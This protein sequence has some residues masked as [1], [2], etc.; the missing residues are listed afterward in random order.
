MAN[1]EAGRRKVVCPSTRGG[2][3]CLHEAFNY[4]FDVILD[5]E[6]KIKREKFLALQADK[7]HKEKHGKRNPRPAHERLEEDEN[8]ISTSPV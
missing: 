1:R 7:D 2:K 3:T 8:K 4:I 6:L 5:L